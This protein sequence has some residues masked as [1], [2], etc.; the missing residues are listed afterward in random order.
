M[1]EGVLA[2]VRA[3]SSPPAPSRSPGRARELDEMTL[4]LAQRGEARAQRRFVDHHAPALYGLL[5]RMLG[6]RG[7]QPMVDDLAQ[8]TMLRAIR[9]LPGFDPQ[10]RA[11][12]STYVLTIGSRLALQSLHK[13]QLVTVPEDD[14][15]LRGGESTSPEAALAALELRRRVQEVVSSLSPEVQAAFVLADA[16]GLTPAEVAEALEVAPATARTRIHRARTRIRA[17]LRQQE[18][19]T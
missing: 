9:A 10:G 18:E 8:E 19:E 4:R 6:P 11:R 17:A 14:V 2:D 16:H 3:M 13:R 12:L 1:V 7:L 15:A 5:S